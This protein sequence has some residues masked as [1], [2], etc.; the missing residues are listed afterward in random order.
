[1]LQARRPSARAH[2]IE[3][4]VADEPL[5]Y[6]FETTKAIRGREARAISKMQS[7]GWEL[8]GEKPGR[9][10][11][12]LIFRRQKTK[13]RWPLM[14]ALSGGAVAAIAVVAAVVA[15]QARND[16]SGAQD[17][18]PGATSM[19]SAE[20]SEAATPSPTESPSEP[21]VLPTEAPGE[22]VVSPTEAPTEPVA[23]EVLTVDTNKDLRTLLT[24]GDDSN[25]SKA[26]ATTYA[27]RRIKFD[28][29]V[30][31]AAPSG[32]YETRF[33]FL[34]YAGDYSETVA[35]PGPAFQ[36][37]DV[38]FLDLGLEGPGSGVGMGD[39]LSIVAEV[40][41]FEARTG[42]FLLE[43]VSTRLR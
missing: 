5:Q 33:D 41:E 20:P 23:D 10:R 39:N 12:E 24:T 6:E 3:G 18:L 27:G 11:T 7:Q 37:R 31:Y 43:P 16:A 36:F 25:L 9:L 21:A 17:A 28:G 2:G 32:N 13:T 30:A 42:L 34:I 15:L 26:F 29:N 35:A 38:N 4:G 14:A 1:M 8:H 40:G 22:P 19:P